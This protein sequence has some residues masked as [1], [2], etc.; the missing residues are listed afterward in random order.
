MDI[1]AM[2]DA[3]EYAACLRRSK[4]TVHPTLFVI[5]ARIENLIKMIIMNFTKCPEGDQI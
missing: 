1:F 2:E 4:L 3:L 5:V